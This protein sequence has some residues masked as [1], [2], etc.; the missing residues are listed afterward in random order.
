MT[1][2]DKRWAD[3][4][5]QLVNNEVDKLGVSGPYTDQMFYDLAMD[6]TTA[7][8][9]E[10]QDFYDESIIKL[11]SSLR[12]DSLKKDQVIKE[13]MEGL[14]KIIKYNFRGNGPSGCDNHCINHPCGPCMDLPSEKWIAKKLLTKHKAYRGEG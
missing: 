4:I 7:I 13:L 1:K 12:I 9:L 5:E 6:T 3:R 11:G 10:M 2:L 14:E 8:A